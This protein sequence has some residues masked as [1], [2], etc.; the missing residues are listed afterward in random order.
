MP[1]P[2]SLAALRDGARYAPHPGAR[3]RRLRLDSQGSG[4]SIEVPGPHGLATAAVDPWLVARGIEVF[5]LRRGAVLLGRPTGST[6]EPSAL[7]TRAMR[8]DLADDLRALP[9][10]LDAGRPYRDVRALAR[11]GSAADVDAYLAE[12]FAT[13][14]RLAPTWE[15]TRPRPPRR[16]PIPE[17]SRV[18]QYRDSVRADADTTGRE[19]LE[20]AL[21]DGDLAPGQRIPAAELWEW[22]NEVFLDLDGVID[23]NGRLVRTPGRSRF[24]A[25][26]DRILGARRTINGTRY[27]VVPGDARHHVP[28]HP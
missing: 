13:V 5:R 23:D 22:A 1:F 4:I 12:A 16:E 18:R 27:Y 21:S 28:P 6:S 24:Y 11:E 26:A 14:R 20:A 3:P 9:D 17:P 8:A 10:R 25:L 19:L 2:N 7:D 15:T